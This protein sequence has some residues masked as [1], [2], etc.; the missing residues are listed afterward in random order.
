M[1]YLSNTSPNLTPGCTAQ[2]TALNG[3][4]CMIDKMRCARAGGYSEGTC[5]E[6][7]GYTAAPHALRPTAEI[8]FQRLPAPRNTDRPS[9]GSTS[10][11]TSFYSRLQVKLEELIDELSYLTTSLG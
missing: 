11:V 1:L 5:G 4:G 10:E 9:D 8:C 6:G 2:L 7:G 3:G